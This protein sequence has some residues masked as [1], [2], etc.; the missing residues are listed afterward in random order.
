[1]RNSDNS[2]REL[3]V[4]VHG[5]WLNGLEWLPMRRRLGRRGYRCVIFHYPSVR[6]PPADNA[7]RLAEFI[8]GLRASRVHVVAHSLGGIVTMHLLERGAEL[9]PGRCIFIGTPAQGSV[10]AARLA[11]L[12]LL[13]RVLGRSVEQG[14]LG[15]AP[16]WQGRRELGVIA[17]DLP[18][19][20]GRLLGPL[21]HPND[22]TV[23]VAETGI[24]ACADSRVVRA[25][26]L[27]LLW[28]GRTAALVDRFLR[29]GRFDGGP[30]EQQ[31]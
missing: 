10:A 25:T 8:A 21:P 22:G 29:L 12:P 31:K 3:V 23:T 14:V 28:S 26:H 19:G 9:A 5:I 11:R 1:M 13:R 7:D 17:G 30:D 18:V 4:L 24:A 16:S 2:P 6:R 20:A 15:G 27:A